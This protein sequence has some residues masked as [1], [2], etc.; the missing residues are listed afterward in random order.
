M[1]QFKLFK[2]KNGF[3]LFE[4]L[5]SIGLLTVIL[6]IILPVWHFELLNKKI[7][8]TNIASRIAASEVENLKQNKFYGL[9]ENGTT[10]FFHPDLIK[11]NQGVGIISVEN[12]LTSSNISLK[13]I[14]IKVSWQ[15][16]QTS[17]Y[18]LNYIF[19]KN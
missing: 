3:S 5:I 4:I 14:S 18:N 13:K 16:N 17:S 7:L 9:P 12:Y 19:I 15:D 1:P 6:A 11:L 8:N 2:N 10:T